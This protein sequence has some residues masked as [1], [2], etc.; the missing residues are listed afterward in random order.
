MKSIIGIVGLR[1]MGYYFISLIIECACAALIDAVFTTDSRRFDRI[2]R[3]TRWHVGALCVLMLVT[4]NLLRSVACMELP[5]G[6]AAAGTL[7]V[8]LFSIGIPGLILTPF[9]IFLA[10][11]YGGRF[12]RW[13]MSEH[14]IAPLK[15]YDQAEAAE[16]RKDFKLAIEIYFKAITD[17]P[18]DAEA[19]RRVA[20]LLVSG[21]KTKDGVEHFRSAIAL[22]EHAE[23]KA[24]L[25][26]WLAEVLTT[27]SDRAGAIGVLTAVKTEFKDTKFADYAEER[28]K[29]IGSA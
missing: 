10:V 19:H 23:S 17:D 11:E 21:G 27:S 14:K 2:R 6:M 4:I 5:G 15:S 12:R 24:T 13:M 28:L 1:F 26:F 25:S 29:K 16:K 20:E 18:R 22:T 9:W 7:M 8:V 3:D